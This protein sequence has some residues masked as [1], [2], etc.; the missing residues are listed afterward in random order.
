MN[1]DK[2]YSARKTRIF[3][4]FIEL[5]VFI[6]IVLISYYFIR[7]YFNPSFELSYASISGYLMVVIWIAF[8]EISIRKIEF[9][10]IKQELI[11]TKKSFF[12]KKKCEVVH[13]S[14]LEFKVKNLNQF[15]SFVVGKK[16]L[17]LLNNCIEFA[18]IRST[19]EFNATEIEE[20]EST[21]KGIKMAVGKV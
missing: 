16:R 10:D 12:G 21:L 11:V 14:Q 3:K 4:K 8:T 9:D 5:I 20:M 6:A 1:N 2:I 15:W 13:Y 7:L 19:Q 17:T 18:K